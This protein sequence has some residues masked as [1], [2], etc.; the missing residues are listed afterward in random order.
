KFEQESFT[1]GNR[2]SWAVIA[3]E[4][5][6]G[7][8]A[9][10]QQSQPIGSLFV[11]VI[12]VFLLWKKEKLFS[13]DLV[14]GLMSRGL[15]PW[16][17]MLRGRDLNELMLAQ[18]LRGYGVRPRTLWVD[19]QSAKGYVKS[20]FE[21]VFKRYVPQSEIDAISEEVMPESERAAY[22]RRKEEEELRGF[23]M[24]TGNLLKLIG[25]R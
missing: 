18:I 6:L 8:T 7:L 3:R 16:R 17:E 19:G 10:A 12:V 23:S 11:D 5:A 22:E 20:D 25:K 15:R 24:R 9:S 13:R 21:G 1:E 4:A 14:A 2:K